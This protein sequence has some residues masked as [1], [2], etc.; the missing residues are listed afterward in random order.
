MAL[1]DKCFLTLTNV[2]DYLNIASSDATR[3]TVFETWLDLI[4]REIEE[5]CETEIAPQ[6]SEIISDGNG[7]KVLNL[8]SYIEDLFGVSDAEKLANLQYRDDSQS[9]WEDL[10]DS[11]DNVEFDGRRVVLLSDDYFPQGRKNI[12][13][14]FYAGFDPVPAQLV[15]VALEKF[16]IMYKESNVGSGS[17]GMDSTNSGAAGSTNASTYKDMESRWSAIYEEYVENDPEDGTVS[18]VYL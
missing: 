3:D 13:V 2:K 8:G 15:K 12:R 16:T 1:T 6:E 5:C 17:L 10:T 14:K 4:C 11:M 7:S 9:A 18:T